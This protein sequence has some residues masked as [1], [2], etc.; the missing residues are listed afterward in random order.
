MPEWGC[1]RRTMTTD[2]AMPRSGQIPL[3]LPH[4]TAYGRDSFIVSASNRDAVA[5]IDQWPH[6]PSP[7]VVLSGPAGSG[8]THLAHVWRGRSRAALVV[9][10]RLREAADALAEGGHCLV[11]DD[12]LAD[13]P[14]EHALFHAINAVR[15]G[16][17]SLLMAAR[18]PA[19]RWTVALPDLASRLRLATPVAIAMPDEA[20]MRQVLVKLFADRQLLV[21]RIVIDYM[22]VRMPRSFEAARSLVA[23]LDRQAL[24]EGRPITRQLAGRVMATDPH[25]QDPASGAV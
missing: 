25:P 4:R 2:A 15:E 6:W 11:V 8:K 23:R 18:L 7:F 13:R 20:L 14:P 22:L 21:D 3:A 19:S 24:A 10:A 12:V 16:G 9:A 17:G 5:F 1:G